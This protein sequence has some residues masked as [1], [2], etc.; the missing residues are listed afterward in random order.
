MLIHLA[1]TP[2]EL[3]LVPQT[4]R[5][6]LASEIARAAR[7]G[8]HSF[9]IE[10][11]AAN[12]LAGHAD[13]NQMSKATLLRLRERYGQFAGMLKDA[14]CYIE[15]SNET[16]AQ[17]SNQARVVH[18]KPEQIVQSS[19]LCS[20]T[21]LVVE[22]IASDGEIYKFLL[23]NIFDKL[24][25]PLP[26]WVLSNG[27]GD[28]IEEMVR[29]DLASKCAVAVLFDTDFWAPTSDPCPKERRVRRVVEEIGWSVVSVFPTP[30]RESENF[31]PLEVMLRH[32]HL[33]AY[34]CCGILHKINVK[35]EDNGAEDP[36]FL[37]YFDMKEG[38]DAETLVKMSDN[39][40]DWV[41]GKLGL[42]GINPEQ[43]P[44]CGFGS[45]IFERIQKDNAAMSLL[46]S[47]IRGSKWLETFGIY[48]KNLLWVLAGAR[49]QFT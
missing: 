42:I 15:V 17:V 9:V 23:E 38:I 18:M 6:E 10:R 37:I 31:I 3:A 41:L 33:A 28:R 46:R 16:R 13:L 48:F 25:V 20:P 21:K 36:K 27:G 45:G 24:R 8:F 34:P 39:Q 47:E 40:R 11:E 43:Q 5:N 49:P 44:I 35:E 1:L 2:A 22:D 4:L 12:W 14:T 19:I 30:C 26:R 29:A 7:H 32:K